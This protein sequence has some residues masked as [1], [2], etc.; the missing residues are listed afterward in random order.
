MTA[1]VA[2][3]P[4]VYRVSSNR[5][6]Y[7]SLTTPSTA[8]F[9]L[10][11]PI[12]LRRD[13]NIDITP[14]KVEQG[15]HLTH[16]L[17]GIRRIQKAVEL[18]RRGS[19]ATNEFSLTQV[20]GLHGFLRFQRQAVK[21]EVVQITGILIVLEDG[22]DVDGVYFGPIWLGRFVEPKRLIFD[23]LGRGQRRTGGTCKGRRT[24]T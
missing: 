1:S 6:L 4:P 11:R 5:L 14:K 3:E 9:N 22:V 13:H 8:T 12:P 21:Q 24:V 17:L 23:S 19:K 18:A 20:A 10:F 16:R 7:S 2:R 15:Q